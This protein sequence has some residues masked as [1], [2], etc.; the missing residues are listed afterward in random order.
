[1]SGD[2]LVVQERLPHYRVPFFEQLRAEL[3]GAGV[4]L[5]VVHGRPSAVDAS[6]ADEGRLPWAR[7]IRTVRAPV[8]GRH[9]VWQPVLRGSRSYDLVV[10]EQ[11]SRM[12]VNYPLLVRQYAGGPRVALWGHGADLQPDGGWASAVG[13]TVKRSISRRPHWWFAYSEGS[14]RRVQAL[15]FD[16]VRITV[17]HNAIDTSWLRP[18]VPRVAARMLY[19]GGLVDEKRLDLLIAA[20]DRAVRALPSAHLV[21]VG[22]G[23]L[24]AKVHALAHTRPHVQLAGRLL[25]PDVHR[26]LCA[27][28]L[29]VV[30]GMVGL[31][32]LDAFHART[33]LVTIAHGRHSP[34]FEYL[35]DGVDGL[36]VP[37]SD[38]DACTAD[39][40]A[41]TLVRTLTSPTE[42]DRLRD[43]CAR[44]DTRHSLDV[45]VDA[46]AG[47]VRRAL[48]VA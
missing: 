31:V 24:R 39:R 29:L 19:V 21:V 44:S 36:V 26:Q 12:L 47:G 42:L 8:A 3:R 45:M 10:V 17:V 16:P 20:A 33:P 5:D 7:V 32:V 27:A 22:D 38:N 15:G 13:E 6:R 34:E 43:G 4:R 30:P 1:M 23:P 28:Q 40:L 2:V 11:A 37:R 46:F 35:S 9:L 25:G 18:D 48:A 14:A 41:Q